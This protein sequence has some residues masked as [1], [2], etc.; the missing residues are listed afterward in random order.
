[1]DSTFVFASLGGPFRIVPI[2]LLCS[3]CT[4]PMTPATGPRAAMETP[5]AGLSV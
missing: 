3:T 1:M 2:S 4:V 5:I